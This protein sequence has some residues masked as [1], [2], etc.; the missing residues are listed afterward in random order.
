MALKGWLYL[1]D[2]WIELMYHVVVL[3]RSVAFVRSEL[4]MKAEEEES[5]NKH[6]E[7]RKIEDPSTAPLLLLIPT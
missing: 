6:K 3:P 2:L 1:Y 4:F 5:R 7:E